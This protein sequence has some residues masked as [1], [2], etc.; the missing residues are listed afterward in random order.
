MSVYVFG[1]KKHSQSEE[2]HAS[3]NCLLTGHGQGVVTSSI[4]V[5]VP[6]MAKIC[7]YQI[8]LLLF[9]QTLK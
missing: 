4:H 9:H 8:I 6:S 1:S 7:V 2:P 3:G 5:S